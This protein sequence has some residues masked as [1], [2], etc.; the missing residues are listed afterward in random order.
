VVAKS[1][2]LVPP[3]LK[4]IP[5]SAAVPVFDTVIGSAVAVVPTAVLE[6]ASGF[7]LSGATVAA[8]G[9]TPLPLRDAVWGEPVPLSETLIVAEKLATDVGV[10]VTC[11]VQLWPVGRDAPHPL[12]KVK[13]LAFVPV[14]V[15]LVMPRVAP[16]E[17][18]RVMGSVAATPTS[19]P[20]KLSGLSTICGPDDRPV[21]V[22]VAV[23][24]EPVE[25]STT[26]MLAVRAPVAVGLKVTVMRHEVFNAR[27]VPQLLVSEKLLAFVP[28]TEMLVMAN[29]VLPGFASVIVIVAAVLP[30][31]VLGKANGF[32]LRTA[33]GPLATVP[34]PLR[35][36]VCVA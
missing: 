14:T 10:K 36:M 23:W 34:V 29:A 8:A 7:G 26:E 9:A 20:G 25:L 1:V 3:R 32:G 4:E 22:S 30:T 13:L 27:L 19:A 12:V 2:G 33:W 18:V 35:A 5:V 21:P 24:G 6:K 17:F 15:I 31:V 28:V 11:S 16:L